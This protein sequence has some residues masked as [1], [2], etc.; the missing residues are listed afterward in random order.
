[1]LERGITKLKKNSTSERPTV[2]LAS[3]T[4]LQGKIDEVDAFVLTP[5]EAHRLMSK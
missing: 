3:I 5:R 1:M 2:E 4:G